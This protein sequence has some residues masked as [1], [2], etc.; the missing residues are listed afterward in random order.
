MALSGIARRAPNHLI[1]AAAEESVRQCPTYTDG[2]APSLS[3][4]FSILSFVSLTLLPRFPFVS[5]CR[6]SS[7]QGPPNAAFRLDT[8]VAMGPALFFLS[9]YLLIISW[10]SGPVM[11]LWDA[12][13]PFSSSAIQSRLTSN[14][15]ILMLIF[16]GVVL[17]DSARHTLFFS[18]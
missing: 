6:L 12:N 18:I 1:R 3:L 15:L 17:L 14:I 9:L 10:R 7:C 5:S 4:P 16:H 8:Q 13:L 2:T 11:G